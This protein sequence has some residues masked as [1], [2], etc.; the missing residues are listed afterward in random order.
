MSK[1][2]EPIPLS[3]VEATAATPQAVTPTTHPGAATIN[4]GLAESL[5]NAVTIDGNAA[6]DKLATKETWGTPEPMGTTGAITEPADARE[7][8][9]ETTTT[10]SEKPEYPDKEVI[11]NNLGERIEGFFGMA[12]SRERNIR[13]S[14]D[15]ARQSTRPL[16][17]LKENGLRTSRTL[18]EVNGGDAQE[19]SN[20]SATIARRAEEQIAH[21]AQTIQSIDAEEQ[22][23]YIKSAEGKFTGEALDAYKEEIRG[24][25]KIENP[26]A[27]DA[28]LV[29]LYQRIRDV[30][31]RI[32]TRA[33]Q[34]HNKT[35]NLREDTKGRTGQ[36]RHGLESA[37]YLLPSLKQKL[38]DSYYRIAGMISDMDG[39][40]QRLRMLS[41][42]VD[43]L[44]LE[45][46]R[47]SNV[48]D[49]R[50]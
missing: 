21:T 46:Q 4:I 10:E 17:D 1:T 8:N 9:T 2:G 25:L 23:A 29:E 50:G 45:F 16:E 14:I 27:R 43:G 40:Y 31:Q 41:Q 5:T 18:R 48:A 44:P 22:F 49:E 42:H 30:A 28:K 11:L 32:D 26:E 33:G 20:S 38:G 34:A 15:G 35:V 3:Q 37:H 6:L 7:S 13:D 47:L 36:M 19:V 24:A 12:R 39:S